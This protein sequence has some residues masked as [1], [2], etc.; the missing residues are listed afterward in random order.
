MNITW[1][2][3]LSHK[4]LQGFQPLLNLPTE[5]V[6]LVFSLSLIL[7]FQPFDETTSLHSKVYFTEIVFEGKGIHGV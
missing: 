4:I 3:F 1:N 5:S 6:E 7:E 2:G